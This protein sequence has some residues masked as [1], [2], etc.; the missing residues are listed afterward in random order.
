MAGVEGG[1]QVGDLR[2]THL[3]DD[4]PVGPH[5]ERLPYEIPQGHPAGALLIRRTGLQPHHMR[6]IG[7]EFRGV[8][9]QDDPLSRAHQAEQAGQQR[10]L[11]D[12]WAKTPL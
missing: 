7:A 1:E 3:A 5:P 4:Q 10:G 8:L 12:S 6:V 2:A 11:D 9:R